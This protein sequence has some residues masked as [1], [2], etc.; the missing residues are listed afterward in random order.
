[1]IWPSVPAI[2]GWYASFILLF[3]FS[4]NS[5]YLI[6]TIAGF[7]RTLRVFQEVR[8]PDQRRLL[9]SPLTPPV[10]VLAPAFN[11]EANVVEN[12]RSLLM[13]DYPLF[14][15]VLVNDGSRDRTLG[16]LVDAFDLR[17]SARSFER[18]LPC[19]P[20]R[21]IYES[22]TYP[23]LVV[24]DKQ[25]GGKADALNAG[26]N[27]SLYPLF[28]AIDAD[29]ILEPDALL[30]L[31][32]PFVDAP[33]V[34]IAAGG[35]VR[36]ANGCDIRGGRVH[37]VRLPRRPLPLIQIVEYLRAFLFGRMGWSTGNT[38]LVISGAF[39]LFE[40]R[41]V[42]LA[43]GYATDSVGEDMELVVRM[44]RQRREQRQPY[45]IGFVPDPICWTEVPVSFRVLRRQRT[46]WQR[47][48]I[49]TLVRHRAMIGR[50]RYGSVGMISLPGFFMFEML[51]PLVE[52]SGYLLLPILWAMGLLNPAVAYTFFLL[53]IMYTVLVSAL[54]VL[55]ED[56]AFR[57]YA[58]V[59]DLGRLLVG[60]VLEN[61]GFRQ[62]TVWWRVRAFWEYLRGD[63]SWGA[64][65]RRGVSATT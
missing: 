34:T 49:D 57:R 47:G 22:P 40:K 61:F 21:G 56:I 26:L 3:F 46:R 63:L 7:W 1:M 18:A 23:N 48:L 55:L 30:R 42:V 36:V 38:L 11:E 8:R 43:G 35:V 17:R 24:V 33:G 19:K 9:R 45:R 4:I 52:F 58:S 64:M 41:A 10:S 50:P 14:E 65:E 53:A 54:A 51:S 37:A 13:L 16:R 28:C 20:I 39:G 59:L 60:A 27:L 15:V 12:V 31:V 29:S 5:Y 25:N 32:R 6:L 44:H 2:L 62:L